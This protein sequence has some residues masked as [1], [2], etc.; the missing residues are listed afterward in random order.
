MTSDNFKHDFFVIGHV[1]IDK[2]LSEQFEQFSIL[3]KMSAK[4]IDL[5]VRCRTRKPNFFLSPHLNVSDITAKCRQSDY[6]RRLT[7][8][9]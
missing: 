3:S 9:F 6:G 8:G 2:F 4:V 7:T 5:E 1:L